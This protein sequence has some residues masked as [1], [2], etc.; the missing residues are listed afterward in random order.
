MAVSPFQRFEHADWIQIF[1]H[2][3]L[4]SFR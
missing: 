3:R 1:E 4:E 2:T